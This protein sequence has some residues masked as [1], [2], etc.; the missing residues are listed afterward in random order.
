MSDTLSR[1]NT[2]V[3][4]HMMGIPERVTGL[5]DDQGGFG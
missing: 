1:R 5:L 3:S 2:Y 4:D